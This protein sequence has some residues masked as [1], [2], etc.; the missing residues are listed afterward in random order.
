MSFPWPD[1]GPNGYGT[2]DDATAVFMCVQHTRNQSV[3]KPSVCFA[4]A[5][6]L[7]VIIKSNVQSCSRPKEFVDGVNQYLPC[8][9]G[10]RSVTDTYSSGGMIYSFIPPLMNR[11]YVSIDTHA[12]YTPFNSS[13]N[14]CSNYTLS[15]FCIYNL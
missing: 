9:H 5:S 4:N 15:Q 14:T 13:S 1:S 3:R 10:Y 2:L 8:Y 11:Y 12:C 7:D 6:A